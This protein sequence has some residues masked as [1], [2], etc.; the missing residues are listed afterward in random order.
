MRFAPNCFLNECVSTDSSRAH[1]TAVYYDKEK[2]RLCA[3]NGFTLV[4]LPVTDDEADVGGYVSAATMKAA[5][6]KGE[7]FLDDTRES[8]S[9]GT[10]KLRPKDIGTFPPIDQ[11][12]PQYKQGD[13]E[14][15]TV[16]FDMAYLAPL[17]KALGCKNK[18]RRGKTVVYLSFPLPTCT[19]KPRTK[20]PIR[21]EGGADGT[22]GVLMPY[23]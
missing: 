18:L 13:T 17:V 10:S 20:D 14:T 23:V 21:V 5:A 15:A 1:L 8:L 16:A 9:D 4:T 3:C 19:T 2:H 6:K 7:L 12:I 11:V 22:V